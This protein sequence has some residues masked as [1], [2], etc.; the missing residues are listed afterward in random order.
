MPTHPGL[1][2]T[3][4]PVT[5]L[6]LDSTLVV[7]EFL[8]SL[9]GAG[10]FRQLLYASHDLELAAQPNRCPVMGDG[11]VMHDASG[12]DD[13]RWYR[14]DLRQRLARHRSGRGV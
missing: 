5:L 8:L 10:R 12:L 11:S 1:L 4:E 7:D 14:E 3:D 9:P 6:N 2:I 13:V